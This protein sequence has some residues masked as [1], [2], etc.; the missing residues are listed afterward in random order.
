MLKHR[1]GPCTLPEW[2]CKIRRGFLE[3]YPHWDLSNVL[4][5][6]REGGKYAPSPRGW[7]KKAMKMWPWLTSW[8]WGI[9][10]DKWAGSTWYEALWAM[11]KI[12]EGLPHRVRGGCWSPQITSEALQEELRQVPR[13]SQAVSQAR[14]PWPGAGSK[15]W[16]LRKPG[17]QPCPH[18]WQSVT[19]GLL[20]ALS[21]HSEFVLVPDWSCWPESQR[22]PVPCHAAERGV[23]DG[24]FLSI[25][26]APLRSQRCSS[27][28][29]HQE[30]K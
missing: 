9:R 16:K 27:L 13:A 14:N 8:I 22:I 26:R 11:M 12:M 23:Y 30:D 7:R 10:E 6:V 28:R 19:P 2:E 4:E 29:Q 24:R 17:T 18:R 21:S 3:E 25:Y 1:E 20:A 15:L 5:L